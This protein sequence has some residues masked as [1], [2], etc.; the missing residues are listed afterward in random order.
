MEQFTIYYGTPEGKAPKIGV[1][2]LYPNRIKAQKIRDG[3]VLEVHTCVYE[4]SRREQELQR[5]YGVRVDDVPYHVVY[6]MNKKA[7]KRTAISTA[8]KGV[9]KSEEAK[10]NMSEARLG[11]PIPKETIL[12]MVAS[13]AGYSHTKETRRKLSEANLGKNLG[14]IPTKETRR[15]ISEANKGKT[16]TDETKARMSE[17]FTG[18]THSTKTIQS[19]KETRRTTT[20]ELDL[21]VIQDIKSGMFQHIAASK[22]NITRKVVRRIIKQMND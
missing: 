12:K 7:E 17:A 10:R 18:R 8:L 13:R 11:K 9:A 5:E 14:N 19:Y 22:H 15:K 20:P 1:D 21:L 2:C 3:R 16:R 6:F 4:V